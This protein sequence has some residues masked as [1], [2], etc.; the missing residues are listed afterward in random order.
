MKYYAEGGG[1]VSKALI[2]AKV[3]I[4]CLYGNSWEF[5]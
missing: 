3:H 4:F 5:N 1:G 2:H